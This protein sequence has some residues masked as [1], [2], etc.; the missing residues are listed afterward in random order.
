MT[1]FG[2]NTIGGSSYGG[3]PYPASADTDVSTQYIA[4]AGDVITKLS[5]YGCTNGGG[6]GSVDVGIYTYVGGVPV[7]RVGYT[8]IPITSPSGAW[9]DATVSISLTAGI[10][11]V[12]AFG[13]KTAT[14]LFFYDLVN[15]YSQQIASTLDNPW[16]QA[17]A[18]TGSF[19]L[20][21]TVINT[22]P[23]PSGDT[24]WFGQP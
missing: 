10:T 5:F 18:P 24:L 20:R 17:N 12:L 13:S 6:D 9:V 19:S 1:I 7:V 8:T 4:I 3:Y 2:Y 16:V 22:P 11:Y 15:T 23:A 21:A 14:V